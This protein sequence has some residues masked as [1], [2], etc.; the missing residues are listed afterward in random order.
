[1]LANYHHSC[2]TRQFSWNLMC[3]TNTLV[4]SGV[5][6]N[7]LHGFI[8]LPYWHH[9]QESTQPHYPN[10]IDRNKHLHRCIPPV[11][12]Q[13]FY[14]AVTEDTISQAILHSHQRDHIVTP[15]VWWVNKHVLIEVPKLIQAATLPVWWVSKHIGT[16]LPNLIHTASPARWVSKPVMYI[17]FLCN[18]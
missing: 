17:T 14:I 3:F 8:V 13:M 4:T 11:G 15:P 1:M 10:I 5:T 9:D 16:E 18:F 2:S 7:S 6:C 12:Q